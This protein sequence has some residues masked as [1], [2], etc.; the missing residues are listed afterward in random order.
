MQL[1]VV[2]KSLDDENSIFLL[3]YPNADLIRLFEII[4]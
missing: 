1:E 4:Y 2:I 3:D